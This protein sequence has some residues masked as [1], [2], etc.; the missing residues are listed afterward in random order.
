MK[1]VDELVDAIKHASDIPLPVIVDRETDAGRVIARG[2]GSRAFIEIDR[3]VILRARLVFVSDVMSAPRHYLRHIARHVA[4]NGGIAFFISHDGGGENPTVITV[5]PDE[6]EAAKP[7]IDAREKAIDDAW[8][9]LTDAAKQYDELHNEGR[10]GF[11]PYVD[12]I[13]D[14]V[15]I[16]NF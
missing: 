2:Y 1:T 11:N 3:R 16:G 14:L 8:K 10:E 6:Y 5:Y 4:D 13:A 15:T 7:A 9:A 12:V